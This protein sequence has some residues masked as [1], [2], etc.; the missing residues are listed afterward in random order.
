MA[1]SL[2]PKSANTPRSQLVRRV[3]YLPRSIDLNKFLM[4]DLAR[5]P[6][7]MSG[8]A[9]FLHRPPPVGE[10]CH[11]GVQSR[12]HRSQRNRQDI[13]DLLVGELMEIRQEQN[14]AQ[15]IR[16]RHDRL[17]HEV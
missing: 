1:K 12:F 17:V 15:M 7:L 3:K 4:G 13:A 2:Y 14:L 16:H 10:M 6:C 9:R 8:G 11:G 5:V